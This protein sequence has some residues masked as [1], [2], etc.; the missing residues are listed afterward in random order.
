MRDE[1]EPG[2][3]PRVRRRPGRKAPTLAVDRVWYPVDT[4]R[5]DL[6]DPLTV[7]GEL[8]VGQGLRLPVADLLPEDLW[9]RRVAQDD[10]IRW[11]IEPHPEGSCWMNVAETRAVVRGIHEVVAET[12]S[13]LR[14]LTTTVDRSPEALG[15]LVEIR[16]H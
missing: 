14:A 2:S 6:A 8:T 5:H 16:H 4:L 7:V 9:I 12:P 13:D 15:F 1:N 10:Q 3:R 11:R